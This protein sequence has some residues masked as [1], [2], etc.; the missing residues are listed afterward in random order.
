MTDRLPPNPS[1]S[2]RQSIGSRETIAP[3]GLDSTPTGSGPFTSLPVA[4][5]RFEVKKQ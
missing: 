1:E 5:G 2:L 3:S 4:F